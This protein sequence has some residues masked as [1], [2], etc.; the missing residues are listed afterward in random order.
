MQSVE[1]EKPFA[2][3]IPMFESILFLSLVAISFTLK[4]LLFIFAM[5]FSA[6]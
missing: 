3:R 5:I 6:Q 2:F 4:P 1:Q